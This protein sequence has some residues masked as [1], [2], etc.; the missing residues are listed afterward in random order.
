MN[1]TFT[2]RLGH[3]PHSSDTGSLV[4]TLASLPAGS[5][6]KRKDADGSITVIRVGGAIAETLPILKPVAV[7]PWK[8]STFQRRILDVLKNG[9]KRSTVMRHVVGA[10]WND[11]GRRGKE[12]LVNL[13]Y[14]TGPSDRGGNWMLTE[15]GQALANEIGGIE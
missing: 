1:R 4:A 12:E 7:G 6:F 14:L 11:R 8:P 9:P 3:W 15:T 10:Q 13:G 5:V 2:P